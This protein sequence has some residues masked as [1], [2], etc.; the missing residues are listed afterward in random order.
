MEPLSAR[1]LHHL[2][3][4]LAR[5]PPQRSPT[6]SRKLAGSRTVRLPAPPQCSPTPSRKLAGSRNARSSAPPQ[7]SLATLSAHLPRRNARSPTLPRNLLTNLSACPAA[8]TL[9]RGTRSVSCV[10]YSCLVGSD[11]ENESVRFRETQ[12]TGEREYRR[13]NG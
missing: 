13:R 6:P 9:A 10:V 2:V 12:K 4:T 11:W 5:R 1:L 7:R 3:S 8:T